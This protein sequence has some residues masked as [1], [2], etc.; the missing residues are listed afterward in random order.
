MRVFLS[1]P[2]GAG[3]S[4]LAW[5]VARQ[6]GFRAVDLDKAIQKKTGRTIERIFRQHGEAYFR[7][8]EGQIV[9]GYLE[10]DN[11]VVA[12]GGGTIV[13]DETRQRLLQ[14]GILITCTAKLSELAR[15]IGKGK[16]RPKIVGDPQT[17]IE[18][19]LAS[20]A[21]MYAECHGVVWTD[22]DGA[23]DEILRIVRENPVA[24][25]LDKRTYTVEIGRKIRHRVAERIEEASKTIFVSDSNTRQWQPSVEGSISIELNQGEEHKNIDAVTQIWDA[26][27]D[28][29]IDRNAYVVAVG[30][31]VVGDVAGFAAAT[32]LRGVHFAQVPTSLIAM[33]DS[34]VGGKTGFNRSSGKN[35]VGAFYQPRFV[36]CDIET[37][38]TLPRREYISG[39]AEVV[40]SAWLAGHEAL[41]V[42]EEHSDALLAQDPDVLSDAI[43]QSVQLKANIVARDERESGTRRLLNAGHTIG[44]GIEAAA[45]YG[46]LRHG[47]AVALGLVA[48]TRV[49]IRYHRT[50]P[51]NAQRLIRLLEQL[52][53]PTDLDAHLNQNVFKFACRDKKRVGDKI[54]FVVLGEPGEAET[55]ALHINEIER[56]VCAI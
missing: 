37:L 34:S 38:T 23:I 48:A 16:G 29:G 22:Q 25:P 2:M 50:S 18:E 15:R 47:E 6:L 54:E 12:L 36:L 42:L 51:E 52:T 9:A 41:R 1:G 21:G 33:V 26:A 35:L 49:G 10:E 55:I 14:S 11:I 5:P 13:I 17:C 45:G 20:R 39:L 8:L 3:K 31:G 44:H 19:L 4:T 27:I 7:K 46:N 24:V 28:T 40:K 32:L 53:L 30:G 43:R 56:A